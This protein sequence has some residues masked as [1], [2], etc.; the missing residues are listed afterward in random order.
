MAKVSVP[1][2]KWLRWTSALLLAAGCAGPPGPTVASAPAV[3]QGQGSFRYY[4]SRGNSLGTSTFTPSSGTTYYSPL[5]NV[6]GRSSS[7][8]PLGGRR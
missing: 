6:T 2:R 4:D 8:M 1:P 3:P 7:P 5:G